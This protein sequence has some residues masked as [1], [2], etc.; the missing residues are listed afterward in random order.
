MQEVLIANGVLNRELNKAGGKFV[1]GSAD[2]DN[3]NPLGLSKAELFR[4]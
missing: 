2:F 4:G 3:E 1:P